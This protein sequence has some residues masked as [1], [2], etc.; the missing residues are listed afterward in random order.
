MD[1]VSKKI[2]CD[3]GNE[4]QGEDG[5]SD[6]SSGGGVGIFGILL[7]IFITLKLCG[8]IDWSWWLVL[9]PIWI[10]TVIV[11]VLVIIIVM[12]SDR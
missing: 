9:S 5:M 10:P 7:A 4:T 11:V 8:V 1:S 12:F 6:K 3:G 2:Q